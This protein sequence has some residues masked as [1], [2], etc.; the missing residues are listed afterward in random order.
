MLHEPCWHGWW[1]VELRVSCLLIESSERRGRGA[2]GRTGE[3]HLHLFGDPDF[4]VLNGPTY[5]LRPNSDRPDMKWPRASRLIS[6][7]FWVSA[8]QRPHLVASY[9][10][11]QLRGQS[12][13]IL[14]AHLYSGLEGENMV[15]PDDALAANPYSY[16]DGLVPSGRVKHVVVFRDPYVLVLGGYAVD[17]SLLDDVQILD[18]RSRRW[19]GVVLKRQCC[20]NVGDVVEMSGLSAEARGEVKLPQMRRGF[21]GDLP[22]PRAEHAGAAAVNGLVYI[23]GGKTQYRESQDFYSFDPVALQWRV[24]DYVMGSNPPRCAGHNFVAESFLSGGTRLVLFGG[25]SSTTSGLLTGLN[26]VW[27]FDTVREV[28]TWDSQ[29]GGGTGA[30]ATPIGR[31]YAAAATTNG[32]LIVFGG[33]DPSSGVAFNDLWAFHLGLKTW[34]LLS[35]NSGATE[36]FAP[37]PLYHATLLPVTR[38][39]PTPATVVASPTPSTG[40]FLLYGGVGGGGAC[41]SHNCTLQET[42]LGQVYRLTLTFTTNAA[43][44][45]RSGSTALDAADTDVLSIPASPG[46]A[47]GYARLTG[48]ASSSHQDRR[49]RLFKE[50]A[51]E[52]TCYDAQRGVMYE[53]GGMQARTSRLATAGQQALQRTAGAGPTG[54][55]SPSLLDAGEIFPVLLW[56][57]STGEQIRQTTQEPVN[58]PWTFQ[59]GFARFQPLLNN[60]LAFLRALRIYSI[61]SA[62]VVLQ[63]EDVRPADPLAP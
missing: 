32:Y 41:G 7:L 57:V 46:P 34:Q 25:R 40:A 39:Q 63:F 17:G 55:S 54:P 30:Q 33:V 28:W 60:S 13:D 61:A 35:K 14:S 22:L 56:D 18:T 36:G 12:A 38:P 20:N 6:L 19:S 50:F 4:L 15:V 47:W 10:E 49:G 52:T 5:I 51:M 53:V 59:D 43:G 3:Q 44:K 27:S 37:P 8:V 31:Q 62:D 11:A 45:V 29:Q 2:Y 16:T 1:A 48:G 9:T 42:V 24:L 21:Q 58:G 26:D 23:F